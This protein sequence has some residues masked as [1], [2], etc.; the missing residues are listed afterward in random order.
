MRISVDALLDCVAAMA[1]LDGVDPA[2]LSGEDATV[3]VERAARLRHA[4][5]AVLAALA[6][7][8]DELS[9]ADAGRFAR[10]KGFT[11]PA[12]LV[13]EVAQV[14]PAD[15]GKLIAIGHAMSGL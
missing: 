14:S 3:W 8:I 7:R 1:P 11:G 2:H 10:A 13:A 4:T 6:Q 5:D 15:A 9:D 12:A